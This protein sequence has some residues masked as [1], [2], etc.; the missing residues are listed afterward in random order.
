MNRR[1][2]ILKTLLLLAAL[3]AVVAGVRM[4]AG[5]QK[6][7]A[8]KIA[9]AI[10]KAGFADWSGVEA[11][12]DGKEAE[13]REKALRKISDQFNRLDFRERERGRE[14]RLGEG[15]F[16]KLSR[17]EKRLFIDL[18]VSESMNRMMEALDAMPERERRKFVKQGLEEITEGRTEQEMQRAKALGDDLLAKMTEE[19]MRAYFE[20]ASID[21]K[22][23]L[24]PLMEAMNEVMQG[25]RGREFGPPHQ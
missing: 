5:N 23:D 15:L 13:R 18:T 6:P 1:A 10:D 4:A 25:L 22:L 2:L 14:M 3:W 9:R 8:D 17:G 19:G 24:A 7:T 16:P 12:A 11:P 20:R 21:T